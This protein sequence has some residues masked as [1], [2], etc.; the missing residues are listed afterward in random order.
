MRQRITR[1]P[2]RDE[3][4][5]TSIEHRTLNGVRC[6]L[7]YKDEW[8]PAFNILTGKFFPEFIRFCVKHK[9]YRGLALARGLGGKLKKPCN[10]WALSH[11][12]V[13][14]EQFE[15][16][17][18]GNALLWCIAGYGWVRELKGLFFMTRVASKTE[19]LRMLDHAK[20]RRDGILIVKTESGEL[21]EYYDRDNVYATD[22]VKIVLEKGE[23]LL[24]DKPPTI[25]VSTPPRMAEKILTNRSL[26]A[27]FGLRSQQILFDNRPVSRIGRLWYKLTKSLSLPLVLGCGLIAACVYVI[28]H[29]GWG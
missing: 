11:I 2:R 20:K 23:R 15:I 26:F 25:N 9:W 16:A 22:P 6:D 5:T 3:M 7:K 17:G 21:L 27:R 1:I 19:Q 29:L 24:T 10:G 28:I 8:V 4:A 12:S 14:G 18:R 13:A